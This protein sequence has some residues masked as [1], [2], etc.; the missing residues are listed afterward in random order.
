AGQ[1][2]CHHILLATPQGRPYP[3]AILVCCR[4]TRHAVVFRNDVFRNAL[5]TRWCRCLASMGAP[6]GP[7]GSV[8]GGP[9]RNA[10]LS[11][12]TEGDVTAVQHHHEFP[13]AYPAE[14]VGEAATVRAWKQLPTIG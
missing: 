7:A 8:P 1:A 11:V 6:L 10:P 9:R 2:L 12:P 13:A 14:T 3:P 5:V 4:F